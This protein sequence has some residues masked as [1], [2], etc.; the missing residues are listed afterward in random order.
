MSK[1]FKKNQQVRYQ[2]PCGAQAG[3]GKVIAVLET[4][5]GLWY[6]VKD[7]STKAVLRLRAANIEAA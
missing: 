7:T 3:T 2:T 6:E 5:R 4:L 1:A